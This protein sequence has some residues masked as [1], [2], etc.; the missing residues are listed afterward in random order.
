MARTP[1]ARQKILV[2]DDDHDIVEMLTLGLSRTGYEVASAYGGNEGL[3]V[4]RRQLPD[5]IL[6]D[7]IMPDKNGFEVLAELKKDEATR[8]IPVVMLSA[9]GESSALMEGQLQGAIDYLIKPCSWEDLLK[10]VR[11][12]IKTIG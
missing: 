6:L 5:L 2:V 11:R 12:Y 9:R 4:A 1:I 10:Y 8:T 7:V 3:A